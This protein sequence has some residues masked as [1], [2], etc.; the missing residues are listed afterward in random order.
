MQQC[1]NAII[2][3]LYV[4]RTSIKLITNYLLRERGNRKH[5]RE[6]R[7]EEYAFASMLKSDTRQQTTDTKLSIHIQ[8]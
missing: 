3:V 1:N 2:P 4:S 7:T 8:N 5:A 6:Q